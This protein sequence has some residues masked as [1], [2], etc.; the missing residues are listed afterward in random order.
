MKVV[1]IF[2]GCFFLVLGLIGVVL[3]GLPTV[4]FLLLTMVC[5]SKGSDRLHQWFLSTNIYHQHL[6]PFQEKKGLKKSTKIAILTFSTT[7]LTLGFY[8][9]PVL[10]AK[11]VIVMILLIKYYVFLFRIKTLEEEKK[12]G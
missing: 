9:T 5:F 6:K 2:L 1:Y 4:P 3:P 8:F 10:W 7:M 11:G 12:N